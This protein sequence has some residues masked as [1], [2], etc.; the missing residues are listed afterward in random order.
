MRF[1]LASSSPARLE[2]LRRA[3]IDPE[4]VVPGV[5]EDRV[6]AP[7]P[8]ELAGRLAQL[9]AEAVM[10]LLADEPG[11]FV[12]VACDSLLELDQVA[13]GKPGSPAAAAA[14]WRQLRGRQGTLH[15]GHH[16]IVRDERGER[17]SNR[18]ASTVV[19]FADLTDAEIDA[20]AATG[21]PQRVAGAFTIDSLGGAFITSIQGDPHNVVGISLPTLR[22]LLLD[23]GVGWHELWREGTIRG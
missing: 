1:V 6:T 7:T 9:K 3:G 18:V 16:V 11:P 14:R 12:L 8:S 13:H 5:D 22:Q 20:Y 15:T 17:S 19:H 21:E 10:A 23:L 4:V 2:T